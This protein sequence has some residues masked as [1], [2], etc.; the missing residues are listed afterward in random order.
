MNSRH[1]F[2]FLL[3]ATLL[4]C[5]AFGQ[6]SLTPPGAPA[7]TMKT[8]DQVE[9]RVPIDAA[10]LTGDENAQFIIGQ[11]GSYYLT[12]NL[13]VTKVEGIRVAAA[14]VTIDLN[15]FEIR[16]TS[17]TGGRGIQINGLAH[18]CT[19]KN[20][21][22]TGFE[23]GVDANPGIERARG[24]TYLDVVA[25]NCSLF[26]L[27]AGEAWL[28]ER[29]QALDNAGTGILALFDSTMKNCIAFGNGG[30]G[31]SAGGASSFIGCRSAQNGGVGIIGN[32]YSSV[33]DCAAFANRG[34]GGI[35]VG[36]GSTITNSTAHANIGYG[37]SVGSGGT[38]QSSTARQ[39]GTHGAIVEVETR[40]L[41]CTLTNNVVHGVSAALGRVSIIR[42]TASLNG[43]NGS[44]GSGISGGIRMDVKD[45]KAIENR[46]RRHLRRRRL[47]RDRQPRQPEW[48]G[49]RRGRHQDHR[50]WQPHRWQSRAR[51]HRH[52]HPRRSE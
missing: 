49:C 24:G 40:I 37:F 27:S 13:E 51:Q 30:P 26:G 7:A 33:I 6:G 39:N 22:V 45:C 50:K 36:F 32:A 8:L 42:S 14:G 29:C 12:G 2:F 16:R 3:P 47:H 48:P 20:G 11:P 41:D 9:A 46:L 19:V 25:S 15:G 5:S 18:R 44:V 35:S 23:R 4:A 21:S 43:G 52:R 1:P 10:H 34:E 17:G 38:L 31:M 28:L